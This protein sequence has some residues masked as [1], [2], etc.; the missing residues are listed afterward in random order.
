MENI[1]SIDGIILNL[2]E[3][4]IK[5]NSDNLSALIMKAL[6][7]KPVIFPL[8]FLGSFQGFVYLGKE[9]KLIL[10]TDHIGSR[11]IFYFH[12]KTENIFI[13]SSNFLNLVKIMQYLGYIPHL[14]MEAAYCLLTFGHMLGDLTLVE[15]VKRLPPGSILIYHNGELLIN[16]YYLLSNNPP[17]SDS[18]EEC[19]HKIA[20]KIAKAVYMEYTKDL[21]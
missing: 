11:P 3:L 8:K 21:E 16:Q 5:G 9:N 12:D 2:K 18:E 13:F 4:L 1:V 17:I 15:G 6:Q 19:V 14:N 20:G 7:G 10:F